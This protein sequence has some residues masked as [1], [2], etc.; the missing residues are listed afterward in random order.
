[1]CLHCSGEMPPLSGVICGN[2][3]VREH[4]GKLCQGAWHG[5]CFRQHHLDRY[6]VL[7]MQDLDDSLID[8]AKCV[9]DDA[10][11]FREARDGD[12]LMTPFQCVHCHFVNI[13]GRYPDQMNHCDSAAKVAITRAILD[14]LWSRERSTVN[15]NR[16]EGIRYLGEL[17]KLG[18]EHAAYPARGP[19]PK[20]D[21]WGMTL[22]C[23]MLGRSL[24]QG[25][26]SKT[27]QYETTRKIRSHYTNFRHTCPGGQGA[28]L[29][30][31]DGGTTVS[32][33]VS[34]SPWFRRFGIGCHRRMGDNWLP[35]K[36]L[37]API[38][39]ACFS[40]LEGHWEGYCSDPHG[41]LKTACTACMLLSGYYGGLRGEEV[42]R[43]DLGLILKHWKESVNHEVQHVPLMLVG[44]FKQ[45]DGEKVFCQ[46][47]SFTTQGGMKI[48]LWFERALQM[49]IQ[50]NIK[51]GPFFRVGVGKRAS[52]A[53]LD[54]QFRSLLKIVQIKFP[55]VINDGEDLEDYSMHISAR[56]GATAEAQ[57]SGIPE[58]VIVA[59]NRWRKRFRSKGLTPGMSMME[60]YTEAKA[61]VPSLVSFSH[62]LRH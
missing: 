15:G 10:E 46:P 25:R 60:R 52:I 6:P 32:C 26:N 48:G 11:R 38:I 31:A 13:T 22:A 47:L 50:Y 24:A 57:N 53:D 7:H 1:M 39:R 55:N 4:Q 49:F 9:S 35:D 61:S 3:G 18:F 29:M 12:H 41:L 27:V 43:I 14:S 40:I 16:L 20:N 56:R 2:F 8:E 58:S 37:T 62:M 42:V 51:S 36:P 17:R 21:I 54:V 30:G 5:K 23:G 45:V 33:S 19:F 28:V 59:N 44:R 34:N